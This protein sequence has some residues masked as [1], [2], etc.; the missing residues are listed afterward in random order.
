MFN[1]LRLCFALCT[2]L[3]TLPIQAE[4]TRLMIRIPPPDDAAGPVQLETAVLQLVWWGHTEEVALDYTLDG[5]DLLVSVPL[6]DSVLSP[7]EPGTLPEFAYVALNFTDFV[8]IRS[9]RFHWLGS[10]AYDSNNTYIPVVTSVNFGFRSGAALTISPGEQQEISLVVRRPD[11]RQ[12]RFVDEAGNAVTD[13]SVSVGDFWANHNHCGYPVG[14]T[15]LLTAVEPD[16][17]GRVVVPDGDIQ[18]L[19]SVVG[20]HISLIEPEFAIDNYF[21]SWIDQPEQVVT[22]RHNVR[23]PLHLRI[24]QGGQA[25]AGAV[26]SAMPDMN[27]CGASA[28]PIGTADAQGVLEIADFY[29]DE[30][31][32][33]CIGS[34][35]PP[36]W[37]A[38]PPRNGEVAIDL[39]PGLNIDEPGLCYLPYGN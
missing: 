30:F 23:A 20:N 28:Y 12:L 32:A 37:A 39:P 33:L 18:Y 36:L 38:P 4:E 14:M 31:T 24:T 3:A 35:T 19:V 29:P 21:L 26:V 7:L 11:K 13:I 27:S 16:A 34:G 6:D 5:R 25:A 22:I 17:E 10:S 1:S 9:G 15:P 2:V 8:P